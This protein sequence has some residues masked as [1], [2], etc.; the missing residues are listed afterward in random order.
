MKK[1]PFYK[2][3][4]LASAGGQAH[5]RGNKEENNSVFPLTSKNKQTKKDKKPQKT[6][7]YTHP[8]ME[9]LNI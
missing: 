5:Y 6:Q 4:Y 1:P 9:A 2:I 7:K 8:K 3:A